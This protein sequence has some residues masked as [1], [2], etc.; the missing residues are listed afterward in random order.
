MVK[1]KAD[2]MAAWMVELLAAKRAEQRVEW[3][4]AKTAETMVDC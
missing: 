1:K 3:M 2:W 4:V